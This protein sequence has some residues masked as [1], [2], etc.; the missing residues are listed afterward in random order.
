MLWLESCEHLLQASLHFRASVFLIQSYLAT[1]FLGRNWNFTGRGISISWTICRIWKVAKVWSEAS[2]SNCGFKYVLPVCPHKCVLTGAAY[3]EGLVSI[4]NAPV[5]HGSSWN[6]MC[7]GG[8][9]ELH[10]GQ[11]IFLLL[12][13]GFQSRK[14]NFRYLKTLLKI[15]PYCRPTENWICW[16]FPSLAIWT[17]AYH[18]W[19]IWSIML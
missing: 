6:E 17:V 5:G 1:A 10:I 2:Q 11:V 3:Y 13:Q 16:L 9:S 12:I 18:L 19:R 15:P 14:R 7:K 8:S 4:L